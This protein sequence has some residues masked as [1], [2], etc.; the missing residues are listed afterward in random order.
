MLNFQLIKKYVDPIYNLDIFENEYVL[1]SS[2][3]GS[4]IARL[5]VDDLTTLKIDIAILGVPEIRGSKFFE[6]AKDISITPIRAA[7]YN[8]YEWHDD[9]NIVDLGDLYRGASLEETYQ[10]LQIICEECLQEGVLLILLGGSHDLLIPQYHAF[11]QLS[12][13]VHLCNT[14]A[15]IDLDEEK[16]YRENTY[17]ETLFF[18]EPSPLESYTHIAFQSYYTHPK[19]LNI[20]TEYNCSCM[21]LGYVKDQPYEVEPEI[22]SANLFAF[23]LSSIAA[24]CSPIS[25]VSPSG[26]NS[27]EACTIARFVGMSEKIQIMGIYGYVSFLP[28]HFLTAQLIAQMI[29]YVIE[30]RYFKREEGNN[31][32]ETKERCNVYYTTLN[33]VNTE[34]YQSRKT[35]RWWMR[36]NEHLF[37][38]CSYNDYKKTANN[39]IPERWLKYAHLANLQKS[40]E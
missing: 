13:P 21:R 9:F 11:Q 17:L 27:E 14:D 22:R 10:N 38:P 33:R 37:V 7:L 16:R 1:N 23:D 31:W 4:R 32:E 18:S 5:G 12:L 8:L 19:L 40:D 24:S 25:G 28:N 20:L 6:R 35:K 3:L 36:I 34:F 39:E 30:G 29:W 2:H 15:L 26:L